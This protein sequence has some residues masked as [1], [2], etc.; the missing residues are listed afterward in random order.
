MMKAVLLEFYKLRRKRVFLMIVLFLLVEIS[1]AFLSVSMAMSRNPDK[2]GWEG[3]V[4][5]I[6]SMNGLFLPILSAVVVSRI[7]DME[8]TGNTWKLLMAA[9]LPRSRIYAAKY[10]CACLLMLLAMILLSIAIAT[11]GLA[12]GFAQP[13]PLSLLLRFMSG[14][15]LANMAVIALQQWISSAVKNQAFGL[16]LGMVGGFIGMTADLF[17]EAVRRIFVWSYYTGLSCVT[18]KYENGTME[19]VTRSVEPALP[20]AVVLMGGA[21]YLIGSIHMSRKEE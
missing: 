14:T 5:T 18:Y 4:V 17:P 19:F 10:A 2:A 9:S 7:S 12:N 8:H 16:G 21:V 6:A 15:M 13:L 11:F 1:W 20:L 3:I